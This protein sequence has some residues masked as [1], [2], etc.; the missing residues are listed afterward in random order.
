MPANLCKWQNV[1]LPYK[2][3]M[4]SGL[5]M[6]CVLCCGWFFI[7]VDSVSIILME[8]RTSATIV[9][10]TCYFESEIDVAVGFY[11][12]DG[13]K[14]FTRTIAIGGDM[15]N[16]MITP[17]PDNV[18]CHC[19]TKR[20]VKCAL[21]NLK[22]EQQAWKCAIPNNGVGLFSNIVYIP[23][24]NVT[25]KPD[26]QKNPLTISPLVLSHLDTNQDDQVQSLI[27]DCKGQE[28]SQLFMTYVAVGILLCVLAIAIAIIL[29]RRQ[30]KA[31]NCRSTTDVEQLQESS[32]DK[33]CRME[34]VSPLL[35]LLNEMSRYPGRTV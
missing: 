20:Q 27:T 13:S 15:G 9:E 32:Q 1:H 28:S 24:P 23:D 33:Q 7:G 10:L 19:V 16:C 2:T 17:L 35:P 34:Y 25:N 31:T 5:L 14:Q 12:K 26:K 6:I 18:T 11:L 3:M 4:L 30:L 22:N 8:N 21:F 29:K